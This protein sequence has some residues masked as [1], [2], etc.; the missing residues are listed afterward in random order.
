MKTDALQVSF[1]ANKTFVKRHAPWWD[2]DLKAQ[3]N[4]SSEAPLDGVGSAISAWVALACSQTLGQELSAQEEQVHGDLAKSAKMKELE[5]WGKFK[6]FSPAS[7]GNLTKS[8]VDP[9]W[10]L[11]WKMMDGVKSVKAR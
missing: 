11:T 8:S 4:L 7:S 2:E 5:A 3:I 1:I 10:V 6:V 9:R